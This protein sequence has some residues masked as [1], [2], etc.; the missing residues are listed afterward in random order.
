L[1]LVACA[2]HNP[3]KSQANRPSQQRHRSVVQKAATPGDLAPCHRLNVRIYTQHATRNIENIL[4]HPDRSRS[5][6]NYYIDYDLQLQFDVWFNKAHSW[7]WNL[8][9]PRTLCPL[10]TP[11]Q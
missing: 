1:A 8:T 6:S 4:K 10:D 5:N 11:K 7:P 3:R 2:A 9:R